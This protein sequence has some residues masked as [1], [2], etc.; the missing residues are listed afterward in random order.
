MHHVIDRRV[1]KRFRFLFERV[2]DLPRPR[3]SWLDAKLAVRMLVKY[4]GLTIVGGLAMAF[5]G[6]PLL[7]TFAAAELPNP[8]AVTI[9]PMVVLFTLAVSVGCGLLFGAIPI[10]LIGITLPPVPVRQRSFRRAGARS[11]RTSP[12]PDG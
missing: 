7:L 3:L 2:R 6:L 8:L 4:P 9:D 5:A 12:G 10:G 1:Q 11:G